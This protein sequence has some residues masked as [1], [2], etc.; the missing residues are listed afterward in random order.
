MIISYRKPLVKIHELIHMGY[1]RTATGLMKVKH[2][3]FARKDHIL[4]MEEDQVMGYVNKLI[5]ISQLESAI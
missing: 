1:S 5:V 4:I 2:P 3:A